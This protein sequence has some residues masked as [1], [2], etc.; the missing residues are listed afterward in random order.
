MSRFEANFG[1]TE[2][3]QPMDKI[4]SFGKPKDCQE[5]HIFLLTDGSVGDTERIVQLVKKHSNLQQRVHTFGIGSGASKQLIVD[6]AKEGMGNHC[7]IYNQ[8][9]IEE[10]VVSSL[11]KMRLNMT[12]ISSLKFYDQK[13]KPIDFKLEDGAVPFIDGSVVKLINLLPPKSS[14]S[15][16]ELTIT[17]LVNN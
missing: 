10:K 1:G 11:T 17:N 5:T 4:F 15:R 14:P 6:C 2:I 3:Y 13:D 16:Y 8:S 12:V 7:F 9:E